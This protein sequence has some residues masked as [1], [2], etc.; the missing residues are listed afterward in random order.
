VIPPSTSLSTSRID[1]MSLLLPS[2]PRRA[3]VLAFWLAL[4]GLTIAVVGPLATV[5]LSPGWAV[6]VTMGV[7][8]MAVSGSLQPGRVVR[9]YAAWNSLATLFV[10]A[11]SVYV[12]ALMF[13]VVIAAAGRSGSALQLARP[14]SAGS[15]W[16]PRTSSGPHSYR[17]QH[18]AP[19][20]RATARGWMRA[21]LQWCRDTG[22]IWAVCLVPFWVLIAAFGIRQGP[23][24]VPTHTYT[25]Y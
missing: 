1:A 19:A 24:R 18:L 6:I 15:L 5:L 22:N 16:I 25:L 10:R 20:S 3:W 21:Y 11:A 23:D 14:G 12:R 7:L 9:M 2:P 4:S 17:H 8:V 13:F